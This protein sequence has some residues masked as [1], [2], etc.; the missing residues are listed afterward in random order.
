MFSFLFVLFLGLIGKAFYGFIYI[1]FKT[2][3]DTDVGQKEGK[4]FACLVLLMF[5]FT[6]NAT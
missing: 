4:Q 3:E 5:W 6:S 2:E 1:F